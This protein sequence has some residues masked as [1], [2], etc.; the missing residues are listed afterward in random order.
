MN[1]RRR[2]GC[3]GRAMLALA[4]VTS[5]LM[6]SCGE[7]RIEDA[8]GAGPGSGGV[9]GGAVTSGASTTSGTSTSSGT[10]MTAGVGGFGEC[11]PPSGQS[12][13]APEVSCV[14]G[15][16]QDQGVITVV[17]AGF[18]QVGPNVV[19]F[20]DFEKGT[21]GE[22]ISTG[23]ASAQVGQW[24]A[25]NTGV[26][27]YGDEHR[28]SGTQAF[29]AD[30]TVDSNQQAFSALPDGTTEIFYSWWQFVP[31]GHNYAGENSIDLLNW[32]V[33]W[34]LG[35][36][37]FAGGTGDDDILLAFLGDGAA[38]TA[39]LGGN[40]SVYTEGAIWPDIQ[41]T[42]GEWKRLWLW[43]RGR[44]D[45][46]GALRIWELRDT[47]VVQHVDEAGV[48]TLP[49]TCG[50]DPRQWETVSFNGYGRLTPAPA[51]AF[52]DDFYLATG[53]GAQARIEI[54]NAATYAGSTKLTVATPTAWSDGAISATVWR[55]AFA[56]G[57]QAYVFVF[58]AEGS[59]NSAA[60]YPVAF[61]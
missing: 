7:G 6:A 26:P 25:L 5:A 24:D 51:D 11:E 8:A 17:G 54:G 45:A 29:K 27:R 4:G 37:S 41:T 44:T 61:Q 47:G 42:K 36:D 39:V 56:A 28:V 22:P 15:S 48:P 30:F 16:V 35:D 19:V 12:A 32:K 10:S 58:D 40:C 38:P 33:V 34:L 13:A 46:T 3:S 57:E 31:T 14:S 43:D 21:V 2:T 53:P 50:A 18:G 20:D 1:L 9:G 59:S 23:P 52:L 55:G 60:G 49:T